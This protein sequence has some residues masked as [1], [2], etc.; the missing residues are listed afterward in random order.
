LLGEWSQDSWN[1]NCGD[2]GLIWILS[3]NYANLGYTIGLVSCT[4]CVIEECTQGVWWNAQ[5]NGCMLINWC[6]NVMN[7]LLS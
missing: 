5:M 7:K 6:W 2:N 4:L 1:E 3:W